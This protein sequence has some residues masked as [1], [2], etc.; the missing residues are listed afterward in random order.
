MIFSVVFCM[1]KSVCTWGFI[2]YWSVSRTGY[3]RIGHETEVTGIHM[4]SKYSTAVCQYP[5]SM[6]FLSQF[7]KKWINGIP[8]PVAPSSLHLVSGLR[9]NA[10][11]QIADVWFDFRLEF[12]FVMLY[13]IASPSS[14][15]SMCQWKY[16]FSSLITVPRF[17]VVIQ[18]KG[19][20]FPLATVCQLG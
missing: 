2:F 10:P 19:M 13:S 1:R 11:F 3:R 4:L 14:P 7:H 20:Q 8:F 9:P 5:H 15:N 17:A 18:L 16:I 6:H 12:P